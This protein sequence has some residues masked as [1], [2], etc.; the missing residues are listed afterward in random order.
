[1][2]KGD[3]PYKELG[4]LFFGELHRQFVKQRAIGK[5]RALGY[6]VILQPAKRVGLIFSY[7]TGLCLH[8]PRTDSKMKLECHGELSFRRRRRSDLLGDTNAQA[9]VP[10]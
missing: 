8:A 6:S 5:L 7:T 10:I 1:M 3:E 9:Q 4:A 2:L